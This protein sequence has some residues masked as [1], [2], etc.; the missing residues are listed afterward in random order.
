MAFDLYKDDKI[1]QAG[2]DSP[3]TITGLT[4]VTQYDNYSVAYKGRSEKTPLSFKT[5]AQAVTGV[6]VDKTAVSVEEGQS[7]TV[8]ATIAPADATDKAGSWKSGNAQTATVDQNGKITG[9]KAGTVNVVYTTHDGS[10]T[11]QVAVTV[12]EPAPAD[13]EPTEPPAEG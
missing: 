2:V 13:P 1:E 6:S 5:T 4:P 9:V 10:K 7:A 11:A 12:T 3:I 8:K